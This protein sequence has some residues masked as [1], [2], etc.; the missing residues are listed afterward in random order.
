MW[1]SLNPD[2]T[3]N[4]SNAKQHTHTSFGILN[5][6]FKTLHN[7]FLVDFSD[8]ISLYISTQVSNPSSRHKENG[9]LP[10]P[11]PGFWNSLGLLYKH[12]RQESRQDNVDTILQ[13]YLFNEDASQSQQ[14]KQ[15]V[16]NAWKISSLLDVLLTLFAF[17]AIA[18]RQ[19]SSWQSNKGEC[20]KKAI[21][22][23]PEVDLVKNPLSR[24]YTHCY[25]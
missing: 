18:I 7:L 25:S 23:K 2:F 4:P 10:F 1:L 5:L 12:Q 11:I 19:R 15:Q 21:L 9:F 17:H 16:N 14:P 6:I 22:T 24:G 20:A 13:V 3:Y 8:L